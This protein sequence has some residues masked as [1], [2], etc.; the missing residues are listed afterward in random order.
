MSLRWVPRG[1]AVVDVNNDF[2][3]QS[4]V[5]HSEFMPNRTTND[6]AVYCK[7]P[8][9]SRKTKKELTAGETV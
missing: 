5:V 8:E 1:N 3:N 7:T 9:K 2:D 4:V 6:S